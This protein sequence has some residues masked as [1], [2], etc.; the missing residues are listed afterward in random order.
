[1][2]SKSAIVICGY[3]L[4][5]DCTLHPLLVER[6]NKGFSLYKPGVP[7]ILAGKMPPK[8]VASHRCET[9]TEAAAMSDFLTAKGV[10]PHN[11]FLEEQSFTTFTNAY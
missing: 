2:K 10:N 8:Q 11:I 5:E 9:K 4:N 7:S 6:L 3:S 1:M